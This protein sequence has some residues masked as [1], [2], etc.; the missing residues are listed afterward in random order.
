M[1]WLFTAFKTDLRYFPICLSS[2][3]TACHS[4]IRLISKW[5]I[6]WWMIKRFDTHTHKAFLHFLS[7]S[8]PYSHSTFSIFRWCVNSSCGEPQW[9]ILS[10]YKNRTWCSTTSVSYATSQN[11]SNAICWL[12]YHHHYHVT[13]P[14]FSPFF[15]A[16]TWFVHVCIIKR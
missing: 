4:F 5:I 7:H 11:T 3:L 8:L 15:S 14:R 6:V 1:I 12:P 16:L 13:A 10:W 2:L 9:M